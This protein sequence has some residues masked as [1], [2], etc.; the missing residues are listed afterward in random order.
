MTIARY[1]APASPVSIAILP[2]R[3][4]ALLQAR[5]HFLHDRSQLIETSVEGRKSRRRKR[6]FVDQASSSEA[7]PGLDRGGSVP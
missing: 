5:R 3:S 4:A 1:T 6:R 2:K 7:C